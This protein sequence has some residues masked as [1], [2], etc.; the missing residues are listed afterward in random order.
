M[1]LSLTLLCTLIAEFSLG[2][3]RQLGNCVLAAQTGGAGGA[4]G[5]VEWTTR[6]VSLP[7]QTDSVSCGL[8]ALQFLVQHV[9]RG[10]FELVGDEAGLLRLVFLHN[11]IL[12]GR[13][14]T[15]RGTVNI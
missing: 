5:P 10:T 2:R 8:F 11:M 15:G 4:A 14:T 1:T 13:A 9:T 12:A 6:R 3:L 7:H